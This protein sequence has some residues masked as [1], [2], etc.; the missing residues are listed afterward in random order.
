MSDSKEMVTIPKLEYERLL[1]ESQWL[2]YLYE[3][4]V[5]NWAGM[6]VAIELRKGND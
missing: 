4:G 3:A 6:E 2:E 5:D 1:E